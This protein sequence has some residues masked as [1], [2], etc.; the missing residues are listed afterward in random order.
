MITD[1]AEWV[2]DWP[3]V[4]HEERRVVQVRFDL[5]EDFVCEESALVRADLSILVNYGK[6]TDMSFGFTFGHELV[7]GF[8]VTPD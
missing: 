7:D 8:E 6:R 3:E 4:E 5:E 2:L 1:H